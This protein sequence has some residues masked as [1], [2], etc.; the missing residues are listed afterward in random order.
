MPVRP[1]LWGQPVDR[2]MT[3]GDSAGR[4]GAMRD[5]WPT[6][7]GRAYNGLEVRP[8]SQLTSTSLCGTGQSRCD[9]L[10][11]V[12]EPEPRRHVVAHRAEDGGERHLVADVHRTT[13]TMPAGS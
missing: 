5:L 7:G 4:P 8:T 6:R 1:T 11:Q 9:P 3:G 2:V 13:E 10:V 12:V